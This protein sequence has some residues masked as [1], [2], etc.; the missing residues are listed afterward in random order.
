MKRSNERLVVEALATLQPNR[1]V[2]DSTIF[3]IDH[4]IASVLADECHAASAYYI[5]TAIAS[6]RAEY[7]QAIKDAIPIQT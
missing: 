1:K 2:L 6:K 4:K 5:V 7:A 3:S